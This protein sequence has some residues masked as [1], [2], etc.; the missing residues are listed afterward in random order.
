MQISHAYLMDY[1][2]SVCMEVCIYYGYGDIRMTE[3]SGID[4][5]VPQSHVIFIAIKTSQGADLA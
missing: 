3:K 5:T 4:P 2:S 1:L